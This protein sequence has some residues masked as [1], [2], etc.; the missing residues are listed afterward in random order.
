MVADVAQLMGE[1]T[2]TLAERLAAAAFISF[3]KNIWS[4]TSAQTMSRF[5]EAFAP[6]RGQSADQVLQN[7]TRFGRQTL[8]PIVAIPTTMG[9]AGSSMARSAVRMLDPEEKDVQ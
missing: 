3:N 9:Y 7:L 6:G 1:V 4:Q 2:G 5:F 8:A